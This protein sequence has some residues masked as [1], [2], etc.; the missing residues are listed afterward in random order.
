MKEIGIRAATGAVYV[1]L[2]LLA[3]L[4][5]PLPTLILFLPVCVIAASELHNLL[6]FTPDTGRMRCMVIAGI[7]YSLIA[8]NSLAPFDLTGAVVAIGLLLLVFVSVA[9]L[10][11]RN[12]PDPGKELGIDLLMIALVAVPFA[13]LTHLVAIDPHLMIGIMILLWTN[14]TGAYLTGK[15]FGKHKMIPSI[16]P[17]KTWE[18]LFGGIGFT[19]L[20]AWFLHMAWP[21]VGLEHWLAIAVI[22]AVLSTLGDLLESALKRA[23]GVKDAGDLLPGHGGILDRFDGLLLVAPGVWAYLLFVL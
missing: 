6:H 1:G 2:T 5:G 13:L 17:K 10:L 14:E 12:P 21:L 20:F 23:R 9:M 3:A 4:V 11:S 16:S 19:V 8:G 18:G 15:F 7:A 22:V